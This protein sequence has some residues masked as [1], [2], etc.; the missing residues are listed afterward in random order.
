[1]QWIVGTFFRTPMTMREVAV[2]HH[3]L[4]IGISFIE[5]E[6]QVK[7]AMMGRFI[8]KIYHKPVSRSITIIKRENQF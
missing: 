8:Y 4:V 1:M 7:N 2:A 5:T 6:V 3:C